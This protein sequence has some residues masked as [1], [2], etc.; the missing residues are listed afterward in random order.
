MSVGDE[1][2]TI[3]E[4]GMSFSSSLILT[5]VVVATLAA[6]TPDGALAMAFSLVFTLH[7]ALI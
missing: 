2:E 3:L 7:H 6:I 4:F 1:F 5:L